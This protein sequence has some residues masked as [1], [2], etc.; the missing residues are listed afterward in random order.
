MSNKVYVTGMGMMS[1]IGNTVAQNLDAL[2]KGQSGIG[3]IR[4][5]ATRHRDTLPV[6]E[7]KC[8][9][10]EMLDH[11]KLDKHQPYT[12]AALI[13]MMAAK[14]AADA[15]AYTPDPAIRTGFISGTT[16]GGMDK[17]EVYYQQFRTSG[18]HI[19]YLN[20]HDCGDSTEKAA[21]YLNIK[22]FV[23]TTSTACSSA[24]NSIMLGVRM[25]QQGRLDRV[26][27]GGVESLTKY[28]LNGFNS[29]MIL[30]NEPCKPFDKE[31][32]GLNLGEGAAFVV[33]ESEALVKAR[34]AQTYCHV[35]GFGNA[36]EAF[37]QTAS[38]PDGKGAYLA[39]EEALQRAKLKAADIDYINAHGTGTENNDLSEGN[40]IQ[41]LF[42]DHMPPVSSTKGYTG[43]T[44]SA[45]GG[46]E[47][48]I[49]ILSLQTGTIFPNL[50]WK[51]PMDE[52][53]FTPV[54]QRMDKVTLNHVL[55]NSFG[56]GGNNSSLIFSRD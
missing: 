20:T 14:E 40:A 24:A 32:K 4:Y 22:D 25:I 19:E 52:L 36:C 33:L 9:N 11:L 1:A 6:G 29:L 39:M 55:S 54:T 49:S 30:D 16:V 23:T 31:R 28:H 37:H 41:R 50:N 18:E 8:S 3:P 43:H 26:F 13:S 45:A 44:T 38:T 17:S 35:S 12:R 53:N 7:I 15:I 51:T 34:E 21:D 5:L 46:I 2:Q 47:A 56:F 48:I 42:E 27:A 10:Q